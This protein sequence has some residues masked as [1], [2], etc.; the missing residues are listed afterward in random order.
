MEVQQREAAPQKEP[1]ALRLLS[2]ATP[3]ICDTTEKS[4]GLNI[5]LKKRRRRESSSE[6][7]HPNT[8]LWMR[9]GLAHYHR[10]RP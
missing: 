8:E 3:L 9:V 2:H 10:Q 5:S 6:G 4:S 7:E 1:G